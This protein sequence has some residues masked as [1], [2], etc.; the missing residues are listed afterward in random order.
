M[1]LIPRTWA[2]IKTQLQAQ[3]EQNTDTPDADDAAY[4][5]VV[6]NRLIVDWENGAWDAGDIPEW[7]ELW[8]TETSGGTIAVGDADYALASNV[9]YLGENVE[10]HYTNGSI[11]YLP[12]IKAFQKQAYVQEGARFC[13]ITGKPG[14]KILNLSWTPTSADG[15]IGAT[16]KF[17]YYK[18]ADGLS[19]DADVVEMSNP[20]WLVDAITS[21]VSNSVNKKALF[22]N[23]AQAIFLKMRNANDRAQDQ[24]VD[25]DELGFGI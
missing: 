23:R 24:T 15:A 25:D 6:A 8:T 20:N 13:F 19:A 10:L 11:E 14:T 18:Y 12:V 9:N 16:I 1:A 21:E 5:L 4:W 3:I 22:G 17:P 7:E 2:Q